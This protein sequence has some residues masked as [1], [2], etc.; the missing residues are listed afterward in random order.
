MKLATYLSA[1]RPRLGAALDERIVDLNAAYA[2][3]ARA[4]GAAVPEAL[5]DAHV[6][7]EAVAFLRGGAAAVDAARDAL[8]HVAQLDPAE[9]ERERLAAPLPAVKLLPPVLAPPKI[10]C[11]AR[12]F[13]DHAKEAGLQVSEIPILF[14]RFPATLVAHGDPI[15][16]P[17]VS[18]QLDWEG[19]MAVVIGKPGRRILKDAAFDHVAGYSIFNDATIRDYQFRVTQY[20]AGKNFD[21]SGPFGP[22]L[23]LKDE[24][25]DPH[26]LDIVTELN[27]EVV[28]GGSTADMIFDVPTIIEHVSEF[29]SLEAGDVIPM[30]TPSGVGFKRTPPRFL[31]PGDVVRISVSGLG[32]LENPVVDEQG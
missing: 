13:A 29:V 8:S 28:Q 14:A 12:N 21:A 10:I 22:F 24:I 6:P 3:L 32:V 17:S 23:V 18:E 25:P 20:T 11:V 16:R 19:E 7:G 9:A 1:G 31:V 30:G 15:V 5:A 27:G 26:A 4:R 2:A